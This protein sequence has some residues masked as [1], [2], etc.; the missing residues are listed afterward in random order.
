[1]DFPFKPAAA[2]SAVAA[3]GLTTYL[4]PQW[5]TLAFTSYFASSFTVYFLGWAFWTVI[6]YPKLFSPLRGLPEPKSQSWFNGNWNKIRAEPSG[7]PML[8][9]ATTIPNEGVIRYLALLNSERLLLTSPKALAEVLVT[10]NY[11]FQKPAMMRYGLGRLLGIGVLLAEGEEHKFQR[12]N[13][14]PA[15]AFR[16]VKD[17]YQVFWEKSREGVQAMVEQIELDAAK[18]PTS[19]TISD[20]EKEALMQDANGKTG[21]MEVGAWASRITL[22]IIGVAGLGR[23]FGA[24]ADPSNKLFKTY[25]MI[26]KPSR[27]AQILG[28][29]GLIMPMWIVARLPV[30]RN[31]DVAEAARTIR[32][33]CHELI[34]EKKEKLARKE[35]TDVDILSVA[36]ESGGFT[37]ENLVDQLMTFLAAGHETTA[38]SMTWAIY[39]LCRYPDVQRRLREEIRSKLPSID[40]ASATIT[41][42]DIDHMPYLNAVCSETLRYFSPVPMTLREAAVD[43]TIQ[44]HKVPKGT[45]IILGVTANNK[46][47]ALWGADAMTFNPDRWMPKHE[48]DKKAASGGATSNYAFMTFLHGPR[49]CIGQ[50]FAK[51]EFAC[52]LASWVGKMEFELQ[53]PE[54]MDESKVEI[55]SNVT[56]RPAK[57][58]RVKVKVLDGW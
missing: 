47:T 14:M 57:G 1:M 8:E 30:K 7:A 53:Y 26:F 48:G 15:F 38:S 19:P 46:D 12:K 20:P 18:E 6:L 51:A 52:L 58:M 21:L 28:L 31:G 2:I 16:H 39:M 34:R 37:D 41:S 13:L 9:W 33:V 40:D 10:K 35:L 4:R 36:L 5:S 49:S 27:Q 24:I 42:L 29:L 22:D 44:G 54:E 3:F 45:R 43:T 25:N 17:L 55:K 50:A 32:E 56:A 23:D 11:D